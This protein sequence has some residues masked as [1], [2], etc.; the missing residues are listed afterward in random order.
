MSSPRP[1]AELSPGD[2]KVS[3]PKTGV[4]RRTKAQRSPFQ[5]S[6][7]RSTFLPSVKERGDQQEEMHKFLALPVEEKTT[8]AARMMTKLKN[9]LLGE[10]EEE[11]ER[12]ILKQTTSRTVVSKPTPGAHELKTALVK[13]RNSNIMKENMTKQ[14][15]Q[16]LIFM[17]RQKAVLELSMMTK[18]SEMTK[19]DRLVVKE[20]RKLIQL[21]NTIVRDKQRF[22]EFLKENERK[23]VEGR[24]L[25]KREEKLK[26]E[27]NIEIKKLAAE[28]GTVKSEISK[29]EDSL[30][31]YKVYKEFLFKISPPEWQHNDKNKTTKTK[32]LSEEDGQ[33]DQNNEA[34]KMATKNSKEKNSQVDV[35]SSEDEA[36]LYFTDPQQL[37]DL[38]TELTEQ[39]LSLIQNAARVEEVLEK[40][41]QF[42]DTTRREIEEEEEQIAVPIKE[43]KQRMDREEERGAELQQMLQR[44]VSLNIKDQDVMLEYLGEKVEQVHHSCVDDRMTNLSTLEKVAN[45]ENLLSS[46]LQS[47][48]SIPE[49]KLQK[50]RK[51]KNSEKRIR[52]REEEQREQK[53]KQKERIRRY[54]ERSL[55]VSKKVSG[56]KLMPK[57]LPV[58]PRVKVMEDYNTPAE[59]DVHKYLF[60]SDDVE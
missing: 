32:V 26:Q 25:F 39:N 33:E 15:K 24:T 42:M 49:E 29:F 51:I 7:D 38:M 45:I 2:F 34:Q 54:L 41:R 11:N 8:H 1:G 44:H 59:D 40:L 55:A 48:E 5:V 20:E 36:E 37:L 60:D 9:E 31:D 50:I 58:S 3:D 47:L 22:E 28:I 57:C 35:D 6:H 43:M 17:E 12:K 23:C 21:E 27:K 14:S 56:R 53:I 10:L 30:I 18:R 16:D 52:Q 46:L 19:M 13:G 4:L